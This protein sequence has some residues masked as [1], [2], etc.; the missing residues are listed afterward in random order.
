MN[1]RQLVNSWKS[2]GEGIDPTNTEAVEKVF[3]ERNAILEVM[4]EREFVQGFYTKFLEKT[5]DGPG[6]LLDTLYTTTG[7]YPSTEDPNFLKRLLAKQEFKDLESPPLQN[8]PALQSS[9][10]FEITPVQRFV[11]NFMHPKTPYRSMLLYHGVGVGKT[12]SAIQA[13]EAYLDMYPDR[14]VII[15]APPTIQDG[16]RRTIFDPSPETLFIGTGDSPNR[17]RQ[18][19]GDTYLRLTGCLYERDRAVIESKVKRAVNRRYLLVGYQRLGNIIQNVITK[20]PNTKSNPH[21]EAEA[22]QKEFNYS[23]LIIDEAHNL[24]EVQEERPSKKN[25]AAAVDETSENDILGGNTKEATAE[26]ASAGPQPKSKAEEKDTLDS[27]KNDLKEAKFLVPRLLTLLNT[28]EGMKLLLMTATPMFNSVYEISFLLS[29]CL[30]NDGKPSINWSDF[31]KSPDTLKEEEEENVFGEVITIFIDDNAKERFGRIASAYV[32]FMRGENPNS[33]PIRLLPLEDRLTTEEYPPLNLRTGLEVNET[34]KENMAKLPMVISTIQPDTE[35]AEVLLPYYEEVQEAGLSLERQNMLLGYGNCVFPGGLVGKKGFQETFA[36]VGTQRTVIDSTWMLL[37]NLD[38]Y[39]PKIATAIRSFNKA[40]GVCFLYSRYVDVGAYVTALILEVNG[41]KRYGYPNLLRGVAA[42]LQCALC[43]SKKSAHEGTDHEFTQAAYILLT[44]DPSISPKNDFMIRAERADD[45][46]NGRKIKVVLGSQIAGEG[47]DL[48]FLREVHILESWFHLN[49]TEQ[50]I[51]RG[52]RFNSHMLL[53]P[54]FRNCTVFLHA[55]KFDPSL[56]DTETSDLYCYRTAL[57]KAIYV[58]HV[59]RQMKIYAMDCNLRQSVTV[60]KKYEEDTKLGFRKRIQIDSHGES[61]NEPGTTNGMYVHDTPFTAI[62]DWM[63][64]CD[65]TCKPDILVKSLTVDE[66]TYDTFGVKYRET[67]LLK[68][69]RGL[70]NRQPFVQANDLVT[71]FKDSGAT[72]LAIELVLRNIVNNKSFRITHGDREGYVTFRNGYFLFQPYDY[73]DIRIPLAIRILEY[74]VK[75]DEYTPELYKDTEITAVAK[76]KASP[77]LTKLQSLWGNLEKWISTA[78]EKAGDV[79]L[80][81]MISAFAKNKSDYKQTLQALE[82]RLKIIRIFCHDIVT[83]KEDLNPILKRALLQYVWDEWLSVEE[84]IILVQDALV[85]GD[86]ALT[87]FKEVLSDAH[88]DPTEQIFWYVDPYSNALRK[89][90]P[91]AGTVP[92]QWKSED[93]STEEYKKEDEE[94]LVADSGHTGDPYG[95][96]VPKRGSVVFKTLTPFVYGQKK[97]KKGESQKPERGLECANV[98]NNTSPAKLKKLG[99]VLRG[100]VSYIGDRK[101]TGAAVLDI[102]ILQKAQID[103]R[104]E[105]N[106]SNSRCT[107][108][109]ITLRFMDKHLKSLG[110]RWFFRPVDAYI[111]DHRGVVSA[112]VKDAAQLEQQSRKREEQKGKKEEQEKKGAEIKVKRQLKKEEAKQARV[113]VKVAEQQVLAAAKKG[114]AAPAEALELLQ[115]AE[116]AK[117][118]TEAAKAA[119]P[120]RKLKASVLAAAAAGKPRRRTMRRR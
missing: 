64:T 89:Q 40:K 32:S 77:E 67:N 42:D 115:K 97:G 5:N 81:G 53:N 74:A 84:Q 111:S 83:S 62:C 9:P 116:A 54:Q 14:K 72:D 100:E 2:E 66:S 37:E 87:P 73:T 94:P 22:L 80:R 104:S 88:V 26:L 19:T 107:L 71:S 95:F 70:L 105:L 93:V 113:E 110:I 21:R 7:S 65:Y 30:I 6:A 4:K 29:L 20:N 45:N 63:E 25:A 82:D 35:I 56:S 43:D 3:E 44:G 91:V 76:A 69:L 46:T 112:E 78:V 18:C 57:Q 1:N 12:C 51:G 60:I 90:V 120:T 102:E 47:L 8:N 10:D 27:E 85:N 41:Y 24:R 39:A 101:V 99:E 55:L 49:K 92:V 103:R 50:I 108:L 16:F 17:C 52:I 36:K 117:A 75:Q 13:A 38:A 114:E 11:A 68:I 34:E 96:L 61:R 31:L 98:S 79:E 28:A 118:A 106:N 23:F 15:V 86:E 58:G 33:F 59:S 48:R 119:K 109:D